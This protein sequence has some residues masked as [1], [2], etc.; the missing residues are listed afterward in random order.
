MF[1][2]M[3]SE[4]L[5]HRTLTKLQSKVVGVEKEVKM[6]LPCTLRQMREHSSSS[7]FTRMRERESE[8]VQ[9]LKIMRSWECESEGERERGKR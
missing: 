6:I 8:R 7:I 9:E 2:A 3:T 1:L 4:R 5:T